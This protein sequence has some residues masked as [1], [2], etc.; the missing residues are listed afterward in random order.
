MPVERRMEPSILGPSA[1]WHV[2]G[3][4]TLLSTFMQVNVEV[5]S[6]RWVPRQES[7]PTFTG[8]KVVQ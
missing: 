8:G 6:L 3:F 4:S 2:T 1:P 7:F 5:L